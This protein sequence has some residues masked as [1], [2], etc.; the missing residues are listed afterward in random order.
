M[1]K[2]SE[3]LLRVLRIEEHIIDLGTQLRRM[4]KRI[5]A[6]ADD[7]KAGIAALN[8]ETDVIAAL[9]TSLAGRI[10]NSMTD[11]EVADVKAALQAESDRLTT[12]G[13]DPTNPVPAPSAPLAAS[14]AKVKP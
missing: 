6:V 3:I 1:N 14:R 4:E 8:A 9:L 13:V 5:M 10:K 12:L 2:S 7:L 11:A